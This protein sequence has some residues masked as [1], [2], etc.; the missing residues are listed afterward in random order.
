MYYKVVNKNL[1][2]AYVGSRDNLKAL[3]IT[4]KVGEWTY[5]EIKGTDL[6]V[7]SDLNSAVSFLKNSGW[8][9]VIF[10]CEICKSDA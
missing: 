7:F 2:S 1:T 4:Y 5:P 3:C 10:E 6:M 8:G 9:E